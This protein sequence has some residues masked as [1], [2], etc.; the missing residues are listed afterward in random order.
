MLVRNNF[1]LQMC[2]ELD[3]CPH[4]EDLSGDRKPVAWYIA[5]CLDLSP[6][7]ITYMVG[8][9]ALC[10]DAIV[11]DHSKYEIHVLKGAL[12]RNLKF[13]EQEFKAIKETWRDNYF[14]KRDSL[15]TALRAAIAWEKVH[16]IDAAITDKY[17]LSF[18]L[19]STSEFDDGMNEVVSKMNDESAGN[20]SIELIGQSTLSQCLNDLYDKISRNFFD[21]MTDELDTSYRKKKLRK[22]KLNDNKKLVAWYLSNFLELKPVDA[23][24]RAKTTALGIDAIAFNDQKREIHLVSGAFTKDKALTECLLCET[25]ANWPDSKELQNDIKADIAKIPK[26]GLAGHLPPEPKVLTPSVGE[27]DKAGQVLDQDKGWQSLDSILRGADNK[28]PDRS[29][30]AITVHFI[31]ASRVSLEE[32]A[33]FLKRIKA[34]MPS[35]HVV[36]LAGND[37]SDR[38]D[39]KLDLREKAALPSTHSIGIQQLFRFGAS[40]LL[41]FALALATW[42]YAASA[43]AYSSVTEGQLIILLLFNFASLFSN[44]T[45]SL[46]RIAMFKKTKPV[47]GKFLDT[48]SFYGRWTIIVGHVIIIAVYFIFRSTVSSDSPPEWPNFIHRWILWTPLAFFTLLNAIWQGVQT[49]INGKEFY[50]YL[51][52]NGPKHVNDSDDVDKRNARRSRSLSNDQIDSEGDSGGPDDP[53]TPGGSSEPIDPASGTDG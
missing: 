32:K 42:S 33:A 41:S 36:I 39:K 44:A 37:L 27:G 25:L 13:P 11:I 40:G 15:L 1:F 28:Q 21:C 24:H 14:V 17:K 46:Q 35:A 45:T 7:S 47:A 16:A 4:D 12:R 48:F 2:K 18:I 22:L 52:G 29:G 26:A 50:S 31:S 49:F 8:I 19:V 43:E 6:S 5:N 3:R 9:E 38:W 20:E 23:L 30:Y 53:T 51:K 10:I 34:Y